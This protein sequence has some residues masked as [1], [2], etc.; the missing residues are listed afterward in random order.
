MKMKKPKQIAFI[1]ILLAITILLLAGFA[2]N[3]TMKN[4]EQVSKKQYEAREME[5]QEA[6]EITTKITERPGNGSVYILISVK[7]ESEIENIIF[8][9]ENKTS[10]TVTPQKPMTSVAKDLKV[11]L[12]KEY[13]VTVN[14]KDGNSLTKTILLE[15]DGTQE[16][17]YI[18]RTKEELQAVNE[19]LSAYYIL[20][21]NIDLTDFTFTPIGTQEEPFTGNI[22]GTGYTISN[23]SIDQQENDNIGLFSCNNGT[24]SNI[25]LENIT[26]KGKSNVGGLVGY[27]TGT[28][29]NCMVSGSVIGLGDNVGGLI[30]QTNTG[31]SGNTS[32]AAVNGKENTGG[33]VGCVYS[34]IAKTIILSENAA[35][36]NVVG[37]AQTGGLI[38]N[39][40]ITIVGRDT[41]TYAIYVQK[42][43]ATGNVE[44]TSNVGGLVGY[45]YRIHTSRSDKSK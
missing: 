39:A 1:I 10:I 5:G 38:G 23:L 32:K 41:G 28:V 11:E 14:T 22:D 12:Q 18:I 45:Q 7:T 27:N 43:Y 30:G 31:I 24:I 21:D 4:H 6:I 20:G 35:E 17:P 37:E 2:I 15:A 19:D 34:N 9:D 42:S 33:L 3:K 40:Y 8:P 13:Q 36:G 16:H 26:V 44:G 29:T 25:T